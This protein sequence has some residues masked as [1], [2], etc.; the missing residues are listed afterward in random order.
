M[1]WKEQ[2]FLDAGEDCGLTIAGFYYVC[3][4]RRTGS[5][6]GAHAR[7]H[8][9]FFCFLQHMASSRLAPA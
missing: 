5:V 9:A 8:A 2:C 7:M 3:M 1:R 4:D 6:D